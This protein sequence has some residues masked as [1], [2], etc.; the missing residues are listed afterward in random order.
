MLRLV[1][2]ENFKN[3][4]LRGLLRQLPGLDAVRVQDVV[5][6]GTPD[7]EILS[8]AADANRI[9]LTH[10]RNTLPNFA[11]DRV[12][13]GKFL[14]GVFLV[15]NTM[16]TRQA[17]AEIALAAELSSQDEWKDRVTYFPL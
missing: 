4:I 12:R 9:L 3:E 1:S 14:P 7:P 11:Y 13:E 16:P 6:A 5:L 8:W 10:D 17:I 2:D 15:S